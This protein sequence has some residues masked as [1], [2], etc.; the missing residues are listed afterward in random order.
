M[1]EQGRVIKRRLRS[2]KNMQQI[3]KAMEMVAAARLRRAQE[4]V[5]AA[6]PYARE[7][8]GMIRRLLPAIPGMAHPLLAN[9]ET[10]PRPGGVVRAGFVVIT[11]DRGLCGGF[12]GHVLRQAQVLLAKEKEYGLITIGRKGRDYF[13]RRGYRLVA[14]FIALGDDPTVTQTREIAQALLDLYEKKLVDEISLVYM[15]F[16]STGRQV[17]KVAKLL[18]VEAPPTDEADQALINDYLFEPEPE[19]VLDMLLPRFIVGQIYNALLESKASEQ[20]ARMI[21][22]GAA[23]ENAAEMIDQLTLSFNKARQAAITKEIS[24]IVG[25]ANAL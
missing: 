11:S 3:T 9:R 16:I 22:M 18:P 1:P 6:R 4:K 20:A 13:R 5:A 25:G 21:A 2:I 7:I 19:K 12:N 24:E 14:E 15:E 17:P 23:S 10:V 8:Q